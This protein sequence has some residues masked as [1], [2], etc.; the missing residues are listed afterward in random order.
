MSIPEALKS[1]QVLASTSK[2]KS[3]DSVVTSEDRGPST[4]LGGDL[5]DPCAELKSQFIPRQSYGFL[6]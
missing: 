6:Y 1:T 2:L 3:R 4:D 5:G